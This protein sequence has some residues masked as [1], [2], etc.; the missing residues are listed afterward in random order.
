MA[1]EAWVNDQLMTAYHMRFKHDEDLMK[2]ILG[3]RLQDRLRRLPAYLGGTELPKRDE[4][5]LDS[6]ESV[7]HELFHSQPA[8]NKRGE[9][10]RLESLE[11]RGLLQQTGDPDIMYMLLERLQSYDLA[12]WAWETADRAILDII[13]ASDKQ[14]PAFWTA[15]PE[16]HPGQFNLPIRSGIPSPDEIETSSRSS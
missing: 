8:T 3:G 11:A 9:I 2:L 1:L 16:E 12:W 5:G 4:D 14:S 15:D 13:A 6:L 7:R 10:D